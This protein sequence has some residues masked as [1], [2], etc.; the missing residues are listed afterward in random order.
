MI[1]CMCDC[2]YTY[3]VIG[4]GGGDRVVVVVVNDW[5]IRRRPRVRRLKGEGGTVMSDYVF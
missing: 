1:G 3:S 5:H 4:G 2:G